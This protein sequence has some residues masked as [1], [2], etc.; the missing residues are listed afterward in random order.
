MIAS[1][2]EISGE[3]RGERAEH[4]PDQCRDDSSLRDIEASRLIFLPRATVRRLRHSPVAL[5]YI[6]SSLPF[7]HERL[8]SC[9]LSCA[10]RPDGLALLECLDELTF[11]IDAQVGLDHGRV[12]WLDGLDHPINGG[13]ASK[14]EDGRFTR[15]Q[16]LPDLAD[17]IV[18]D[19]NVGQRAG[20]GTGT[21][22]MTG[23]I[24][25]VVPRDFATSLG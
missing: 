15:L 8:A 1:D 5:S 20:Y 3:Y 10:F 9:L 24:S 14:E 13:I 19:S 4:D 16:R 17:Q 11:T 25:Q 2:R 22:F 6:N 12:V 23:W 21:I 18:I 7:R